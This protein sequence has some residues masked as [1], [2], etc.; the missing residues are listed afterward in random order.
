MENT[1]YIELYKPGG[2][3]PVELGDRFSN[4]YVVKCKLS[5]RGYQ[6]D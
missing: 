5:Y 6:T 2:Y 4:R 3:H 1:K